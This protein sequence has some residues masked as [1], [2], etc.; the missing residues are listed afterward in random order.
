MNVI[1]FPSKR[2]N[3]IAYCCI[4]RTYLCN[5]TDS[6]NIIKNI[7][8]YTISNIV[9]KNYDTFQ[10]LDEDTI[11]K[12]VTDLGY[13]YALVYSTGTEF[14]NGTSVFD[15][16]DRLTT[17]DFFVYGHILDRSTAYYE[18]HHQCYLIDLR[19]YKEFN[20]PIIGKQQLGSVHQQ[21]KPIRSIENIHDDYTPKYV[22]QGDTIETYHHKM[23]GYNLIQTVLNSGYE[24]RAFNDI[25]RDNKKYYYPENNTEFLKH[26]SFI[27][28]R[29]NYCMNTFIH[30]EHT[31]ELDISQM[32][33]QI[34]TTASGTGLYKNLNTNG[35]LILFDY[36]KA[37][38]EYHSKKIVGLD[39]ETVLIDLLG[40]YNIN[41][42]VRYPGKTTLI[43][44]NNVFNYEGTMAFSSL[45]YRLYKENMLL[46]MLPKHWDILITQHSYSGFGNE[47][48]ITKLTKPTW[49]MNGDWT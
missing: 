1:K 35:K 15:E 37:A 28:A 12:Y 21:I 17:F 44:L 38:L 49:H 46:S 36:N 5:D 3:N 34:I 48:D 40:V 11:L 9:D 31:D 22:S 26:S 16:I 32:Y 2:K 25:I 4:D 19:K 47:N 33:D 7:S 24:I 20:Y 8:D 13:D 45:K 29:Y 18:L 39:V 43:N 6:L 10:S 41:D 23:H 27:Y 42:L 14:I 30:K